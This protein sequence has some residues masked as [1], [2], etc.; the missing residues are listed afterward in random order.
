MRGENILLSLVRKPSSPA[1][2]FQ[3][4]AIMITHYQKILDRGLSEGTESILPT[5]SSFQKER[6]ELNKPNLLFPDL[7]NHPTSPVEK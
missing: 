7:L 4:Q 6:W 3:K 1:N 5:V 2:R